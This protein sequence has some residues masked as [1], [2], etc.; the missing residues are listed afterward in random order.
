LRIKAGKE[1]VCRS[2]LP[3]S[4]SSLVPTLNLAQKRFYAENRLAGTFLPITCVRLGKKEEALRLLR[5]EY[6]RHS[7]AF[8][9]VRQNVDLLTL[10]KEPS[11]QDLLRKIHSPAPEPTTN[12]SS[13]QD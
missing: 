6:D 8:L 7:V 3:G 9:M 1:T 5:Q 10:N 11:Y 2:E 13:T 4:H 12:S